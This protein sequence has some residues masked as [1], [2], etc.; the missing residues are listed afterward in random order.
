MTYKYH[1]DGV[2]YTR[3]LPWTPSDLAA[4]RAGN[5]A[6]NKAERAHQDRLDHTPDALLAIKERRDDYAS[7]RFRE[8][9][10]IMGRPPVM[11]YPKGPAVLAVIGNSRI[12]IEHTATGNPLDKWMTL[13]KRH[14]LLAA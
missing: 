4:V 7:I 3:C 14:K 11:E 6:Q 5:A 13:A 1:I 2:T 12:E 10:R 9:K 8:Y